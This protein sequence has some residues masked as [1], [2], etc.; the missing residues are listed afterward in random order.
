MKRTILFAGLFLTAIS[1]GGNTDRDAVL[2]LMDE[3][4]LAE[5]VESKYAGLFTGSLR[6]GDGYN[7]VWIR[8]YNTFIELAMDYMPDSAIR[9]A[10]NTFFAFQGEDGNIV[11]GYMEREKAEENTYDYRYAPSRPWLVAHKNTVETDQEASLVQAVRKYVDKSGNFD[12]LDER[13]DGISV[14][15]RLERALAYLRDC[16]TDA[17]YGLLTGATTADWGDVQPEHD[18]G[19]AIDANTHFAIDI[20]DNAMYVLA[21][22]DYLALVPDGERS[23]AW[24]SLRDSV[25]GNVRKFLWDAGRRKFIPHIYLEDSPFPAGF[26]ENAIYYHGGTAVAALAGFLSR[27]EVLEAYGRMEENRRAAG[28]QTVGLTMYPP[29]PEG[30][31]RNP[32]MYPYGY[33]N[34]GDWTWFGARMVEA[35]VKY[36]FYREAYE[37]LRPMLQRIVDNNGFYEWYRP[38]G[39]PEGSGTFRGEAGVIYRAVHALRNTESCND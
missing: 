13:V 39:T 1:C 4:G 29:Y 34:G 23:A 14:R 28:A 12:Y 3:E 18:W 16:K 27:E 24:K 31:F 21:I 36:G 11:D 19:V 35:L 37:A 22:D 17:R 7:E 9:G 32:G 26:D 15:E 8:D 20:Y 30:F 5:R 25:A 38:D 2:R 6:A 10:L 33:Q